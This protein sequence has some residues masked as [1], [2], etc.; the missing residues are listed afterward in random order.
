MGTRLRRY[1]GGS[2]WQRLILIGVR[3]RQGNGDG[4][5]VLLEDVD[6][7]EERLS[8]PQVAEAVWNLW[9]YQLLFDPRTRTTHS[10]SRFQC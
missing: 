2:R 7:Q 9:W 4:Q 5:V 6:S 10:P 3:V 8:R 1:E